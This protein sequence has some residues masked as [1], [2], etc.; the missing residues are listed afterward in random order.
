MSELEAA[1]LRLQLVDFEANTERRRA[2]ARHFRDIAP[3][4]AWQTDHPD[5][6]YHLCVA[7]FSNRDRARAELTAA[8]IGTAIHYPLAITQQPAYRDLG[9]PD[10]PR[11]EQWA[12][13]CVSVP[14][15]PELTDAEVEAVGHALAT[16]AP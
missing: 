16:V 13:E 4:L 8:G 7:R 11:A 12:A 14:C 15:F 2:I 5:H 6:V 10:C 1:W 9:G 3:H